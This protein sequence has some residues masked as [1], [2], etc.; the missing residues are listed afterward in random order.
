MVGCLV[1]LLFQVSATAF[2]RPGGQRAGRRAPK[3]AAEAASS[4]GDARAA[5][6]ARTGGAKE[7]ALRRGQRISTP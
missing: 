3:Q 5:E 6:R 1:F 4:R 7:E 2:V